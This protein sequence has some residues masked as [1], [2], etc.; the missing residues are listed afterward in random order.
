MSEM[1]DGKTRVGEDAD[2]D[3][4]DGVMSLSE[5]YQEEFEFSQDSDKTR[6]N[7]QIEFLENQYSQLAGKYSEVKKE[8]DQYAERVQDLEEFAEEAKE[9]RIEAKLDE[10]IE[11]EKKIKPGKRDEFR[12][13]LE[14]NFEGTVSILEMIDEGS[15]APESGV[16]TDNSSTPKTENRTRQILESR[17]LIPVEEEQELEFYAKTKPNWEDGEDYFVTWDLDRYDV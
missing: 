10:V 11:E 7:A 5:L 15:A 6:D 1:A 12:A 3:F 9:N 14:E 8:R 2:P 4:V 13:K 16:N 17:G